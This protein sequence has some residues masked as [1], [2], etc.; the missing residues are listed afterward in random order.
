MRHSSAFISYLGYRALFW[1]SMLENDTEK[2]DSYMEEMD[3]NLDK[4]NT[5]ELLEVLKYMMIID[6]IYNRQR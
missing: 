3:N 5:D 2:M 6:S 4:M 1:K